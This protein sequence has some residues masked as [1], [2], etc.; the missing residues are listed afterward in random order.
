MSTAYHPQTD[1]QSERTIQTLEDMLRGCVI[2]FGGSWDVHPPLAEFSYN[3]SYHLSIRCAPFEALYGR[4]CR[5][6]VLWAEIGE[7][8]LIRL[9]L[10]QETTDK[11]VLIKEKLK[12]E[13]DRQ[14]S[15]ADNRRKPLE[16]EVGDQVLLKVS[17]WKGV[18]R[19]GKK[20]KLAP[21]YVGPFEILERIGPVAYRLR[22]PEELSSVYDT[23]HVS[24]LKK[25]LADANLHVP[26]DEIKVDKT[27]H[28]VE[29]PIEIMDREVKSLKR[30]KISIVKVRWNSK[31]GPEFTW[32]R[33]DHMKAKADVF[34]DEEKECEEEDGEELK[35]AINH[36]HLDIVEVSLNSVMRFT[37]NR[38]MKLRGKNREVLVLIDCGAT[39]NFISSKIIEERRLKVSDSGTFNEHG[40]TDAILRIKWLQTLGDV[41]MNWKLLT[42]KFM[43]GLAEVTL[44]GDPSLCRSKL[45][46]KAMEKLLKSNAECYLVELKELDAHKSSYQGVNTEPLRKL[47]LQY[48]D[49][50]N[51]PFGLPPSHAHEHVQKDEIEKVVREMLE[52][53]IKQP[54]V[55]PFSSSIL[56][57]KDKDGSW[58]FCVDYR[59]LNNAIILDKFP[60]PVI[61]ELLDEVQGAKI[62]SKIDLKSGY[63]QI[64][65]KSSDIQKTAFRTH[66]GHYEF[67]MM[68]F[69]LTNAPATF[70][71]L[72]NK[73]FKSYLCKF[74]LVFFD[75]ILVYSRS[76]E[77]EVHLRTVLQILKE[78]KLYAN[79]K[80]CSFTQEQ[81]EYLG[82]VV[83]RDGVAAGLSKVKAMLEW[84]VPKSICE[85][86]GFLGLTGYYQKFVKGYGKIASHLL[87]QLKKVRF[88]WNDKANEA[89]KTL[90]ATMSTLHVLVLPNFSQPFVIEADASGFR[91]WA[92][93]LQ[94]KRAIAYFSQVLGPRARLKSVYEREL[95][96]IVLAI[97]KWRPY[98]LGRKFIVRTDQRSLKYLLEQRLVLKSIKDGYQNWYEYCTKFSMK[99]VQNWTNQDTERN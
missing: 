37:P 79:W 42:M 88:K 89:F 12:A 11:V 19:F 33:E 97:R 38:M 63:Y 73:V 45:S 18:I 25:C 34:V 94:N 17:P 83:T 66:K 60:I 29:E 59:A 36:A 35:M 8:R 3:N 77:D 2:D 32:E 82:H 78:H 67:L 13:R 44:C 56:L 28:F 96:A 51:M 9:E 30:S 6:P 55:S 61:Y 91:I 68:P 50:F 86:R 31:R 70:Q 95:M 43:V 81:I 20:G 76:V 75:D 39:H 10:V 62:F 80:K 84:P 46:L 52:A 24:N 58:H 22:F 71:S 40:S 54:S 65:M 85:L 5:S 92:V 47:L 1:G 90:R 64:K 16:F 72:M 14:K 74:I 48:E 53:G 23:F 69:G 87:G 21:R 41:R 27:L 99:T 98:L 15:Y 4:K 26:L 7:S 93:L 49:V 57:V